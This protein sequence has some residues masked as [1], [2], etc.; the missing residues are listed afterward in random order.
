[1]LDY[2]F[3]YNRDRKSGKYF[4]EKSYPY[5]D[6]ESCKVTWYLDSVLKRCRKHESGAKFKFKM[7]L[8]WQKL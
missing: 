4:V 5:K 1:M 6:G 2:C 3:S 7:V 8:I